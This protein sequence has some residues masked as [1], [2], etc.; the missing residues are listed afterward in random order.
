MCVQC[1]KEFS[2]KHQAERQ[3]KRQAA[4]DAGKCTNFWKCTNPASCSGGMCTSCFQEY[5]AKQVYTQPVVAVATVVVV[6]EVPKKAPEP[7]NFPSLPSSKAVKQQ[8]LRAW[9]VGLTDAV[10][11][12]LRAPPPPEEPQP[13]MRTL[14][15]I[16]AWNG[17]PEFVYDDGTAKWGDDQPRQSSAWGDDQPTDEELAEWDQPT[18]AVAEWDQPDDAYDRLNQRLR[19]E[20]D[21]PYP[22]EEV[23]G[24]Y[25][26]EEE[27]EYEPRKRR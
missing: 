1:Y 2:A 11:A 21:E 18:E 14:V 26:D 17:E 7:M 25:E 20:E 22:E 5:K 27:D 10:K 9:G 23:G 3:G 13:K 8:P 4:I 12:S 15:A 19:Q 16:S 24:Y 6:Q